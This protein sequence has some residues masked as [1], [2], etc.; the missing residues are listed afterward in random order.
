M[1]KILKTLG[2][3]GAYLQIIKVIS[4]KPVPTLLNRD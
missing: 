2:R 1:I 4:N 3:D